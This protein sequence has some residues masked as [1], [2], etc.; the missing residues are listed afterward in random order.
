MNVFQVEAEVRNEC[1]GQSFDQLAD[2]L[3]EMGVE[4]DRN[5]I[6]R[7]EMVQK[8]VDLEIYAFTH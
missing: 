4:V 2:A 8:L 3:R 6:T 7:D 1:I 5:E